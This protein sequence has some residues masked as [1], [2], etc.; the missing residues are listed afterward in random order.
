[1]DTTCYLNTEIKWLSNDD[2]TV[3]VIDRDIFVP[4]VNELYVFIFRFGFW[5]TGKGKKGGEPESEMKQYMDQMDRELA[6][7]T[8]GQSFEKVASTKVK[9]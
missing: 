6:S 5:F 4:T 1:M 7:S 2:T 3:Y 9:V 8:I